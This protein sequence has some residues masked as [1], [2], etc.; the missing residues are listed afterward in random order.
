MDPHTSRQSPLDL[1]DL[2]IIVTASDFETLEERTPAFRKKL[3]EVGLDS[4]EPIATVIVVSSDDQIYSMIQ[5]HPEVDFLVP[6]EFLK[7]DLK[8]NHLTRVIS[9][10]HTLLAAKKSNP[11][12]TRKCGLLR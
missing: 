11:L 3:Q 7:P 5:S 4:S 9:A 1:W 12:Q 10:R 6:T 2:G 8:M